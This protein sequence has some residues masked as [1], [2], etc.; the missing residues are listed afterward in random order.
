MKYQFY[1]CP[2]SP[3][4]PQGTGSPP[5]MSICVLNFYFTPEICTC[6]QSKEFK[7]AEPVSLKVENLF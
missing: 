2:G 3:T 5:Q 4:S 1:E 6:L 7:K